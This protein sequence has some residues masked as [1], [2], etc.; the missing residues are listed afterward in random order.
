MSQRMPTG[1]V[2]SL[3]MF[4]EQSPPFFVFTG[5]R[6]ETCGTGVGLRDRI[7]G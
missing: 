6:E 5:E 1:M 4:L 3:L 2:H 7:P